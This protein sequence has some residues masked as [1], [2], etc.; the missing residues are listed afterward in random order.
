MKKKAVAPRQVRIIG[1]TWKRTP[2]PVPLAEGLRPTPDRVRETLFNWLG[3]LQS[4]GW[5]QIDCLDLFAGTGALGFEAASRGARKVVLVESHPAALQQLNA[6]RDKL[7]ATQ[8]SVLRADALQWAAGMTDKF[9]LI[10]LDPPYQLQLLPRLLP[11]CRSLLAP[12]GLVYAESEQPFDE[13]SRP[14]WLT[15]WTIVRA[16]KAGMVHYALFQLDDSAQN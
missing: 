12:G 7:A 2:L 1:G 16:D 10:F 13:E 5:H 3:F 6:T 8:V 15:G 11:L 4:G 9:N 14:D